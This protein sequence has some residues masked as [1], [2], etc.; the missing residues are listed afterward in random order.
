VATLV[1]LT[2]VTS[3]RYEREVALGPHVVRLRPAPH[4]RTHIPGYALKVAPCQHAIHWQHDP[5]GNWLARIL[6]PEKTSRLDIEVSL[7]AEMTVVNPFDFLIDPQTAEY[8]FAYPDELVAELVPYLEVEPAG[9]LLKSFLSSLPTRTQ[10]TATFLVDVNAR[11]SREIRYV[12]RQETGVQTPEETLSLGSGSCRDSAWLLVQ[13]LRRLGIAARFVSGY[14]IQLRADIDP[15]EGSKGPL[16][17]SADLHAWA[18]VYLPGAGWIGLDATSGLLCA[19]GH[20]PLAAAPH[21][22]SAAPISGSSEAAS[23]GF[24][25]EMRV[26]RLSEGP[27]IANPFSGESWRK[28]DAL[29]ERV[30]ADLAA[31]DV[32][33][34]LGG[35]PTF[36]SLDDFEAP[37]WNI[38]ALGP[39]KRILADNVVRRL[40]ERFAPG[41]LLHYGEGK[42][43]PGENLPR[44]AFSLYWRRD[45]GPLWGDPSLIAGESGGSSAGIAE[46]RRLIEGLASRLGVDSGR[47]IAAF[48][49]EAFWRER[50]KELPI[51]ASPM[52]SRIAD[53][54]RRARFERVFARGL[55]T[56][57][58]FVLPIRR[59]NAADE[60]HGTPRWMSEHWRVRRE[61][62][63]LVPGDRPL[64]QRL[65]L[66]SLPTLPSSENPYVVEQDPFEERGPL[67]HPSLSQPILEPVE[68]DRAGDDPGDE[69][70]VQADVVRT[71]LAVEPREGVLHVFMPPVDRAEDYLALAAA[72]EE[73]ARATGLIIQLE[74]YAPPFDPRLC[75]IKV[76]PDPGVIEVNIHPAF[77]WREA[78]SITM[79]VYEDAR[80]VR[81]CAEKFMRDGRQIG[82]GGGSHIVLGGPTPADSPFLRRPDLLK[83]FIIYWQRH[84]SL[85]YLFSGL[86][87]GPT[88]QAPRVDE[89]RHDA[90]YEL[91]I[92]MA[93]VPPG[94]D[95]APPPWLVD[96]LFRHLLVDVSG[97]THRAE[98]CIDK[99][100]SPDAAMGRLGLVEFRAF[101]MAP[102]PRMSLAQQLLLRA[103]A[104][105]F[106]R[107]PQEGR[108]VRFGT[109]LHDRYML[110]E[111]VFADFREV[112]EDLERAGY[113]FD[114]LWF[115]A[116]RE[117]RFPVCG[118]MEIGGVRLEL[119][120]ALEPWPVLGEESGAVGTVRYVD[121]SVERLQLKLEGMTQGRHAVLCNGRRLP[122]TSTGV[123]G[124]AVAGVRFR[125]WRPISGLHPAIGPHAPLAFDLVDLWSNRSFGRCVYHV[126]HPG[127]RNYE[128]FPVNSREAE[129]RR[130]AR[131]QH[132]GQIGLRIEVPPEEPPGEF[133]TTLDLRRPRGI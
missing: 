99:L 65:P 111:F 6:F 64:G 114:P 89:A 83:S 42:S 57:V 41:G 77:S 124:E 8:P 58:G 118:T 97:N 125:A 45:G 20:V 123:A 28:L 3:Y 110:P 49:D 38:A 84:P 35:E 33:L 75:V 130:L 126:D 96:R 88:S 108:L 30:D 25:V 133:P 9:P 105:W 48:E 109:S 73:T 2:H 80:H 19:E 55:D 24:E 106:W 23:V 70:E 68:E 117:F 82:T 93:R 113:A 104:A 14:L 101:E 15:L 63:F 47:I 120:H 39:T 116:Q 31:Q 115:E 44:W 61:R 40:R 74:G 66:S 10:E 13:I 26:E 36:V 87:V 122:L 1:A 72:V 132:H 60:A 11:L 53:P 85:S 131:F 7:T 69:P 52:D 79:G 103:L 86:F 81:L 119:R 12:V 98:I 34:T 16:E 102:D 43:Y 94:S 71:A 56:P 32:R 90:L 54:D 59:R 21:Y 107:E 129:G 112:L 95:G 5:L 17:D 18:E 22:R 37:E 78:V 4:R 67:P 76:T 29:G 91:E 127:G 50:E 92:A 51:D 62:L 46:A 100:Y 27:A 121:S 128:V